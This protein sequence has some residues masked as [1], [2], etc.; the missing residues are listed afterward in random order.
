[1]EAVRKKNSQG[2]EPKSSTIVGGDTGGEWWQTELELEHLFLA[3]VAMEF[4]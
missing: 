2:R 3:M 1:M 4:Q